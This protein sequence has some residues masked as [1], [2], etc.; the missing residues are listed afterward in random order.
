MFVCE[1]YINSLVDSPISNFISLII[2]CKFSIASG[3]STSHFNSSYCQL[4]FLS[5]GVVF[6]GA[7]SGTLQKAIDQGLIRNTGL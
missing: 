1:Y 3:R 6:R 2:Q 5:I 4:K 7:G